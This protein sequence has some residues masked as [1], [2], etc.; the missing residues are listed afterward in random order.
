[1]T[2]ATGTGAGPGVS[3][4]AAEEATFNEQGTALA[5]ALATQLRGFN[6][7]SVAVEVIG[8][9]D[10]KGSTGRK[11]GRERAERVITA[12]REAELTIPLRAT[13]MPG[14]DDAPAERVR[15][16]LER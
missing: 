10:S 11:L 15:V 12:L 7:A 2:L 1:M 5:A 16:V 9:G 4:F 8:F 14:S 6:P 13:G 3:A